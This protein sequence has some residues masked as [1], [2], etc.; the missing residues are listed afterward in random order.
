MHKQ[1]DRVE[2][3]QMAHAMHLDVMDTVLTHHVLVIIVPHIV[4][5]ITLDTMLDGIVFHTY[6]YCQ[7]HLQVLV[8]VR[9]HLLVVAAR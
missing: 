4:A 9:H 7:E 2:D 1:T 8:V 5:T 6:Q 3:S